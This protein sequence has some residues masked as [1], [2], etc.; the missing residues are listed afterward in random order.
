VSKFVKNL[1]KNGQKMV[2]K[3]SK[4]CPRN[5]SNFFTSV[6]TYVQRGY[7]FCF[8]VVLA[9]SLIKILHY[10]P[11]SPCF[12]HIA[13]CHAPLPCNLARQPCPA[14]LPGS[15]ARQ[16]C[17]AALPKYYKFINRQNCKLF[18]ERRPPCSIAYFYRPKADSLVYDFSAINK[19]LRLLSLVY[20]LM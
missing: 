6:G 9:V 3:L 13:A 2:K 20:K 1:S 7:K 15:L 5:V 11:I 10:C 4:N 18:Y 19:T 8:V 12:Q 16:P 17:P 14:A